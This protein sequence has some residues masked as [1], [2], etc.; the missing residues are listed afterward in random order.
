[1]RYTAAPLK[2]VKY[3]RPLPSMVTSF[4]PIERLPFV[5]FRQDLRLSGLQ[6]SP[7]D[8]WLATHFQPVPLRCRR[9]RTLG[10]Q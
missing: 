5:F 8:T 3:R 4:G 9:R 2:S 6:V 7:R 10:M 1:M